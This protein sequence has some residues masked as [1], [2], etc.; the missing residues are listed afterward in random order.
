MA[1]PLTAVIYLHAS[2]AEMGLLGSVALIPWVAAMV[3]AFLLLGWLTATGSQNA[4]TLAFDRER[5][6]IAAAMRAHIDAVARDLVVI[7]A[8]TELLEYARFCTELTA[9]TRG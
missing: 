2:P 8:G 9:A 1:L 4:V 7:P 3:V 6:Q 5:E